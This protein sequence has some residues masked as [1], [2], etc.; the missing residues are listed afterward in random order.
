MLVRLLVSYPETDPEYTVI[1]VL[2][3]G[4]TRNPVYGG[5]QPLEL[6]KDFVSAVN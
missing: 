6:V 4:L 3:T 5:N 2:F 1:C